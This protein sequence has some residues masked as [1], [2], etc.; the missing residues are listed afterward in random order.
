MKNIEN[1]AKQQ[2]YQAKAPAI[3]HQKVASCQ[4]PEEELKIS[5]I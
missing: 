4:K 2:E 1:T 5:N 3:I